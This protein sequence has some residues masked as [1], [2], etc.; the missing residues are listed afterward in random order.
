MDAEAVLANAAEACPQHSP[1][2]LDCYVDSHGKQKHVC[3][4]YP[5]HKPTQVP[6]KAKLKVQ[7]KTEKL[8]EA[9]VTLK[10]WGCLR[11]RLSFLLELCC[12]Q[13]DCFCG[14]AVSG[15]PSVPTSTTFRCV[16]SRTVAVES[17]FLSQGPRI[18]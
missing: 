13:C 18:M 17:F 4:G 3:E 7:P 14:K 1:G 9:P 16:A 6:S 8:L 10:A 12:F 11:G 5:D 2:F 15:P